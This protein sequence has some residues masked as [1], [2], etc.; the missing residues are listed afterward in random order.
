MRVSACGQEFSEH[1]H[2]GI[3]H[4]PR[5]MMAAIQKLHAAMHANSVSTSRLLMDYRVEQQLPSRQHP[6]PLSVATP[7][8][9]PLFCAGLRLRW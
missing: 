1:T 4:L 2:T 9:W 6:F 5:H 3:C 8:S 7:P